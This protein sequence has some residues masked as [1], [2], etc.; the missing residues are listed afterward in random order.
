M[1]PA[2]A[3]RKL[4]LIEPDGTPTRRGVIAGFFH[5]GEGLGGRR[6][7]GTGR[8]AIIR[9]RTSIFDL[10]NL[11]AGHRFTP[12]GDNPH[13]GRS[14]RGVRE[15]LPASG[16]PRLSGDGCAA[17]LRRRRGGS[18]A[19]TWW[20]IPATAIV[21]STDQLRHG[22]PGTRAD[23]VAQPVRCTSP[24]RRTHRVGTLAGVAGR[25]TRQRV[26]TTG[27]GRAADV[28]AAQ[29]RATAAV[30]ASAVFESRKAEG[31]RRRT[32]IASRKTVLLTLY[33]RLPPSAFRLPPSAFRLPP[34]HA[35]PR[36]HR[37]S[38]RAG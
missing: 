19:R 25:R 36:C 14:G 16:S 11:R 32:K 22:R 20:S 4:G 13:G 29:R 17:G 33:F 23:R 8:R 9:W 28:P 7:A 31:S 37:P 6:R 24:P 26:A 18:R 12:E 3:W 10:A 5:H 34:S 35:P 2:L 27:A 1:T 15:G 21:C 38:A 30:S